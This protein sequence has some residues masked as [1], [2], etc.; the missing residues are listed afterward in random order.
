MVDLKSYFQNRRNLIGLIVFLVLVLA[1]PLG[2][3][4]VRNTQI[5]APRAESESLSLADGACVKTINGKRVLTCKTASLKLI[6]PFAEGGTVCPVPSSTASSS[7]S[8]SSSAAA[9]PSVSVSASPSS[10]PLQSSSPSPSPLCSPA[11]GST[12]K[13]MVDLVLDDSSSMECLAGQTDSQCKLKQLQNAVKNLKPLFRQNDLVGIQGLQ[14]IFLPISL[15]SSNSTQFDQVINNFTATHSTPL[16]NGLSIAEDEVNRALG[17]YSGYNNKVVIL[18]TDGCPDSGQSP[19][20]QGQ[21]MKNAGMTVAVLGI[22][23]GTDVTK[24]E[25]WG[26]LTGARQMMTDTAS[27]GLFFEVDNPENIPSALKNIFTESVCSA[28]S[29]LNRPKTAAI[30]FSPI[31][32]G[33]FIVRE[34]RAQTG[35]VLKI[36]SAGTPSGGIYP[37]MDLLVNGTVVKSI[38][39]VQGNPYGVHQVDTYTHPTTLTASQVKIIYTNNDVAPSTGPGEDRNLK[40]DKIN[41]DGEDFQTEAPTTYS[42]GVWKN[43]ACSSGGFLLDEWLSCGNGYFAYNQSSP[44]APS[45]SIIPSPSLF[46]SPSPSPSPGVN[47]CSGL[48]SYRIAESEAGL[49]SASYSAYNLNP[50]LTNFNLANG[51]PGSKQIW[52]E[53]KNNFTGQ[54][55]KSHITV[56]LVAEYPVAKSAECT[57]DVNRQNLKVSLSGLGFGQSAGKLTSK[58]SELDILSW[59]D[60]QI[61]AILKNPNLQADN[62]KFEFVLTRNDGQVTREPIICAVDSSLIALG[63]RVFCRNPGMFDVPNVRITITDE[64]NNRVEETVTIAQ[65]GTISGL[66]TKLQTG[67]KYAISIKAP[68]SV[69]TNAFFTASSG[70]TFVS[71]NGQPFILPIGDIAPV[72]LPDG[73]I[74]TLDRSEIVRQWTILGNST[75]SRTGDFNRDTK[76]NSIDW[77]CMRY[78]FNKEDESLPDLTASPAPSPTSSSIA[79]PADAK[80][81]PDGS[82]VGRVGPNCEFAACPNQSPLPSVSS[83]SPSPLP[84]GQRAAYF[85]PVP[86]GTGSYPLNSQFSIDINIWSQN[87]AANLF[88][89][90][91]KFNPENLE[92]VSIQ[93]GTVLTNWVDSSFVN[94]TG[95]VSLVAGLPSPGLKTTQGNDPLM[96]K[97]FFKGKKAGAATIIMTNESAIYSNSDNANIISGLISAPVVITQ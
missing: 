94:S 85:L 52:I 74:N 97:V 29:G 71:E 70:T 55:Y 62:Q 17:V 86:Q 92:V 95:D 38:P 59:K 44:P 80:I 40:V 96:A 93:K 22:Q 37:S 36:Y 6:A 53:Y 79:C 81:C 56:D 43:G 65:D 23:L 11:P 69:R 19:V 9:S 68:Y 14:E 77:A 25:Q 78:D 27:P 8:P 32:L 89:A 4:L 20:Q 60:T 72:I 41:I 45:A 90:Q 73:K 75:L 58:G 15:V 66:K 42:A 16:L 76:V 88:S 1:I 82:S 50:T 64:S 26:G 61:S 54:T 30:N 7:V 3:Y 47:V 46:P 67:R 83:P 49:G 24:C 87:E 91:L 35:S 5:F 34:A 2:I 51:D 12:D 18:V 63:A 10:S 28:D 39:S 57:M 33:K 84:S 13:V 31:N 48:V 21:K